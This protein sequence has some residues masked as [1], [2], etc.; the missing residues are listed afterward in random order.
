MR[1]EFTHCCVC[2]HVEQIARQKREQ[3]ELDKQRIQ[4]FQAK[5]E[6][7]KLNIGIGESCCLQA[8]E[9]RFVSRMCL[10]AR[11]HVRLMCACGACRVV[12]CGQ[13]GSELVRQLIEQNIIPPSR[14]SHTRTHMSH[15]PPPPPTH[16]HI[17][18]RSSARSSAY[19][20]CVSR[21]SYFYS[22]ARHTHSLFEIGCALFF[23][24]FTSHFHM[25]IDFHLLSS[26]STQL[27]HSRVLCVSLFCLSVLLSVSLH[28]LF[29]VLLAR[30]N[31][32]DVSTKSY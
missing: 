1:A 5:A 29:L 28:C 18:T 11:C 24:S 31:S 16:T 2:V 9:Y 4:M 21:H 14:K 12:G 10:G 17:H 20:L 22:S 6:S 30:E 23:R 19:C 15:R 27:T 7:I 32:G 8:Y 26:S 25:S 3:E 13:I